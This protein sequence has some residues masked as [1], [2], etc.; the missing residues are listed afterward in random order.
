MVDIYRDAGP[1]RRTDTYLE[2]TPTTPLAT[3]DQSP[4][5]CSVTSKLKKHTPTGTSVNNINSRQN[6][7]KSINLIKAFSAAYAHI[8][9]YEA[10]R[11]FGSFLIAA[12]SIFMAAIRETS[13]I[14]VA[15]GVA[16]ALTSSIALAQLARRWATEG[17]TIQEHFDTHLY[18]MEW[19]SGRSK[20]EP[21]RI[22]IL[23]LRFRGSEEKL[24]DW[25]PDVSGLL[26][27]FGVL[28]CQR[29]NVA[30]DIQLRRRWKAAVEFFL[31]AWC[32]A[33][34]TVGIAQELTVLEMILRW[35]APSSGLILLAWDTVRTQQSIISERSEL[36]SRISAELDWIAPSIG[37]TATNRL[38]STCREI[39]DGI[40]ATR[41]QTAAVPRF[42][43]NHFRK[44]DQE[45]METAAGE[46]GGGPSNS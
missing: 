30:W 20:V 14:L 42:F 27:P 39:Q 23:S 45:A 41:A 40:Y 1:A 24:R 7:E 25:Y 3:F 12:A 21:E 15:I 35:F 46:I 6:S 36:C 22:H 33:G 43:Y 37:K 5:A 11:F 32:L 19:K 8:K 29:S 31:L 9:R 17:A 13:P 44:N 38:K 2:V 34:V 28:I 10:A 26:S 4:E 16:W 18:E